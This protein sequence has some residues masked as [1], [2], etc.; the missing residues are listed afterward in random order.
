[1]LYTLADTVA[2]SALPDILKKFTYA[3]ENTERA[4]IIYCLGS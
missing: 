3:Q 4:E 2:S 1:M